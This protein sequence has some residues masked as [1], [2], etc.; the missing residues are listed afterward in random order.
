MVVPTSEGAHLLRPA[1]DGRI[2]SFLCVLCALRGGAFDG[3]PTAGM[4][5]TDGSQLDYYKR[6][7]L[8]LLRPQGARIRTHV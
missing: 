2:A 6:L 5:L 7:R 4:K 1:R 8:K 3:G